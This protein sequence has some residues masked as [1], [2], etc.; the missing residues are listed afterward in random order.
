MG[1]KQL[2]FLS[3]GIRGRVASPLP[4]RLIFPLTVCG[5]C[6]RHSWLGGSGGTEISNQISTLAGV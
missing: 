2:H 3:H 5:Q 4:H 6:T 1:M